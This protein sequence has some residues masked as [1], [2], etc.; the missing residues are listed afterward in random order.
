MTADQLRQWRAD[1]T[2]HVLIDVREPSEHAVNRI[3]GAILIPL[4]QLPGRLSEIPKGQ[5]VVV[6]CKMGGRSAIAVGMLKLAGYD[7]HNLKGGIQ[8]WEK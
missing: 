6:H 8:A 4:R 3:D 2:P 1:G 7:A 5:P